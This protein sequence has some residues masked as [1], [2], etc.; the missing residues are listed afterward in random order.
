MP[1]QHALHLLLQLPHEGRLLRR[2]VRRLG[3]LVLGRLHAATDTQTSNM[4]RP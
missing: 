3:R 4:T 2:L 1:R